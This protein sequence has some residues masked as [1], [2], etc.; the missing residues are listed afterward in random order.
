MKQYKA[1]FLDWDDTIGDFRNAAQDS[2]RD[3]FDTY[4]LA[5]HFTDF[6]TFSD[7]Y[8]RHNVS[9]WERYGRDE[10]T[11][12][13]LSFDRFFYPLMHA[14]S[15]YSL[16]EALR[17][18]PL[19]GNDHLEHTT[20]YFRLLPDAAEVVRLL[21][22]RYPLIIVSNGFIEVQY[23]KIALSGLEDCFQHVVLSE[24]VGA[25]KPN[26]RIYEEALRLAGCQ[27]DEVLMIGDSW[28]SDIQG[29]IRAGIDQAW[30][31]SANCPD[32]NLPSTYKLTCLRDV[33]SLLI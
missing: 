1:L 4:Q 23:R 21:A 32:P 2:L 22:A 15:P 13:Y 5:E 30:I 7:I 28:T 17:L 24:E 29:A 10:V 16:E 25:Q 6:Q 14:P 26:P 33:L 31:Q 8:N 12:A 20:R 27:A 9:L 11:K 3:M 19:L 18:A